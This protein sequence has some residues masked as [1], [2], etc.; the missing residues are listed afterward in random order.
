MY[1]WHICLGIQ[2]W[3]TVG[4]Q[5]FLKESERV[6]LQLSINSPSFLF[7][8][9]INMSQY[10]TGSMTNHS[11]SSKIFVLGFYCTWTRILRYQLEIALNFNFY[12]VTNFCSWLSDNWFYSTFDYVHHL[13]L[14]L[15]TKWV[16][17]MYKYLKL[18][19]H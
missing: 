12:L 14:F 8:E 4:P 13:L 9:E 5:D 1:L 7:N 17:K 18:G 15:H 3:V 11:P 2:T 16:V 10:F 6:L 19:S